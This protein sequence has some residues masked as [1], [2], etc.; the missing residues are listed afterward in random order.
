MFSSKMGAFGRKTPHNLDERGA[1]LP[2]TQAGD[3]FLPPGLLHFSRNPAGTAAFA[4]KMR[5]FKNIASFTQSLGLMALTS[6]S[7]RSARVI[8]GA[9]AT[10]KQLLAAER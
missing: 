2:R 8:L 9:R 6:T 7:I 1:P 4:D 3:C 10:T 5:L